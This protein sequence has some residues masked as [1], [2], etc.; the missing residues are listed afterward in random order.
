MSLVIPDVGSQVY[1][2]AGLRAGLQLGSFLWAWPRGGVQ[3]LL[4]K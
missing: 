3:S 1:V 2:K 4:A